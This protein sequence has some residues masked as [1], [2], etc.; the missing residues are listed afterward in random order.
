[1]KIGAFKEIHRA[2]NQCMHLVTQWGVSTNQ[3]FDCRSLNNLFRCILYIDF[4]KDSP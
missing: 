3:A 2:Q 1:M 4:R